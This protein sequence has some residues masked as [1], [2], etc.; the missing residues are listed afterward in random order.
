MPGPKSDFGRRLNKVWNIG[1]QHALYDAHGRFYMPLERFPGVLL[2][3]KGYVLFATKNEFSSCSHLAIGERVHVRS[4][5][6]SDIPNYRRMK[7]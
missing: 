7:L 5:T 3:P 1:A 4:G 6:I 2:D